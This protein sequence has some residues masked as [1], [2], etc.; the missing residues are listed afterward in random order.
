NA[1]GWWTANKPAMTGLALLCFLAHEELPGRSAEFGGTV[2]RGIE[3]L[4][5]AYNENTRS[6]A[7]ADGNE[8][9]HLIAAYAL[10]E[11]YGMTRNPTLRGVTESA[12]QRIIEGQHP[13]GGW[14]YKMAQ[15]DRDDTSYM[16]WAAQTLR[17][18]QVAG[19]FANNPEWSA[20][21]D[22]ACKLSNNGFLKNGASGGGFGYT[23]PGRAGLTAVGVLCMQYH[24]AAKHRQV[25]DSLKLMREWKP[26]WVADLGDA[27]KLGLGECVQYYY[28]YAT[29]ALYLLG[30]KPWDNWNAAM[31][32]TY[33]RAQKI[34]RAAIA[35]PDGVMRDAGWWENADNH[36]D[37]PVMD[38]CLAILQLEV[39]YRGE[40][41]FTLGLAAMQGRENALDDNDITLDIGSL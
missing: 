36:S 39:Y 28:Y 29:Q 9:A 13:T 8:Y 7:G 1:D 5:A 35:G 26:G 32:K 18:A 23:G 38:T 3:F 2:R 15:S 6:F 22:K 31:V 12:I 33:E 4:A 10:C 24:G 21:L 19:L 11:A 20:K 34:Q 16:G 30:G 41:N 27:A 14:D 17:A 25:A 37:R 40:R